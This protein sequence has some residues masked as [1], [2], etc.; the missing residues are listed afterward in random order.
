MEAFIDNEQFFEGVGIDG[1]YLPV[2][3][4][5]QCLGMEPLETF[6]CSDVMKKPKIQADMERYKLHLED[7]IKV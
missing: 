2:H 5:N 1:V 7:A 3:K 4:A 6:I